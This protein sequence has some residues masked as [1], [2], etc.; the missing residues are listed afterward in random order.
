MPLGY[1]ALLGYGSS[2]LTTV[3]I[4]TASSPAPAF[5]ALQPST[6]Q[7]TGLPTLSLSLRPVFVP[8][9]SASVLWGRMDFMAAFKVLFDES[10]Q[11][12]TLIW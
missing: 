11:Q 6:A 10:A 12:F 1:A 3:T 4:G 5:E 2:T 8:G 9:S 7:P